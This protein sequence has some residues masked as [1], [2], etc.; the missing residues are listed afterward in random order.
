VTVTGGAAW[1]YSPE[2]KT[3]CLSVA[4]HPERQTPVVVQCG[5]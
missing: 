3:V 2:A 5:L 1:S 4:E